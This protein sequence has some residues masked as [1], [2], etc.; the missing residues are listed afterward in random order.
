MDQLF[1]DGGPYHIGTSPLICSANQWTGFYMKGT[2]VIKELICKRMQFL[3][4]IN[5]RLD[6]LLHQDQFAAFS[7]S[8]SEK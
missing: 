8:A 5:S 2:S 6:I 1:H 7:T 4:Q 3:K